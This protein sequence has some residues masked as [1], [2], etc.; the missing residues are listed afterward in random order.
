M[1]M[2]TYY[3][4]DMAE[5]DP[6]GHLAAAGLDSTTVASIAGGNLRRLLALYR[7]GVAFFPAA[8]E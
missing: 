3:P 7:A 8:C 6:I 5:S 4:Y 1:L 2:G